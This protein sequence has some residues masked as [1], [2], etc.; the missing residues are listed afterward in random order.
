MKWRHGS[1]AE[2]LKAV[3]DESGLFTG[4]DQE[5]YGFM[6][7]GFQERQAAP[8]IRSRAFNDP[9]MLR[10]LAGHFGESWW[11]EV[12]LLMLALDD[13]SLSTPYTP[14]VVAR[15]CKTTWKAPRVKGL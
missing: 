2:F 11:E 13:P 10:E 14:E 4:W 5:H 3:R 8:E 1:A 6:P 7:L 12:A 15:I 9:G